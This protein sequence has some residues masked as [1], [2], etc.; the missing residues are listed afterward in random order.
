MLWWSADDVVM[1]ISSIDDVDCWFPPAGAIWQKWALRLGPAAHYE[2]DVEDED[3]I[4][5][6]YTST[7][8]SPSTN[9]FFPP[10]REFAMIWISVS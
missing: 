4:H 9:V 7:S 1:V 2:Y 8:A 5:L 3:K 10:S 6:Y